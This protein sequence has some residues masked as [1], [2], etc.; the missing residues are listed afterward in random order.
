V[1][2]IF[3]DIGLRQV[4]S[5]RLAGHLAGMEAMRNAYEILLGKSTDG[6]II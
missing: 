6:R 5:I 2:R 3:W 1:I 4:R